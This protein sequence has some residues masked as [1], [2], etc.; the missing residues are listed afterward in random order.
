MV[1]LIVFGSNHFRGVACG[2]G[3]SGVNTTRDTGNNPARFDTGGNSA[4]CGNGVVEAGEDCDDG[5]RF[6]DDGCNNQCHNSNCGDGQVSLPRKTVMMVIASTPMPVVMIALQRCGDGVTR[7]DLASDD[8]G[9]EACDDATRLRT[10][11]AFHHAS[12]RA[13]GMAS[14]VL[15]STKVNSVMKPATTGMKTRPM[16]ASTTVS[17]RY[18]VTEKL[19]QM[20]PVMMEIVLIRMPVVTPVNSHNVVTA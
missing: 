17:C 4:M 5:N 18:A 20:K 2:P 7:T 8:R 12:Q 16:N 1:R 15:I 9:Y 10:T 11:P 19:A 6:D 3:P 13:A 14:T